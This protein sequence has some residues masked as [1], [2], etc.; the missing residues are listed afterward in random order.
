MARRSSLE[1]AQ[2]FELLSPPSGSHVSVFSSSDDEIVWSVSSLS[3]S[4]RALF[5]PRSE[6]Y[7]VLSPPSVASSHATNVQPFIEDDLISNPSILSQPPTPQPHLPSR[8]NRRKRN[9][10]ARAQQQ[11][12]RGQASPQSPPKASDKKAPASPQSPKRRKKRFEKRNDASPPRGK[13]KDLI[14]APP[15]PASSTKGLGARSVVDDVSERD[16]NDSAYGDGRS[17]L[18]SDVYDK[19]VHYINCFLSSPLDHKTADLALLQALIIELGFFNPPSA[20][21]FRSDSG[22]STPSFELSDIPQSM[23]AAKLFIKSYVFLNVRD[24]LALRAQGQEALQNV[25]HS[26]RKSLVT[27]LRKKDARV[28]RDWV[29]RKG[30][31]ALLVTCF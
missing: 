4:D 8:R 17:E 28:P 21:D 26:S 13:C 5:S 20:T 29:K 9:C 24:Y 15:A 30:L 2:S 1:S 16:D 3:L 25:L 7:V 18:S 19:A 10:N 23:R 14:V 31:N 22:R 12:T 6:D 11:S 27:E